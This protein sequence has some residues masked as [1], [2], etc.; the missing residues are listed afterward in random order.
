MTPDRPRA[1]RVLVSYASEDEPL[2]DKLG[3]HLALLVR[4]GLVEVWDQ[5]ALTIG[6]DVE[7]ETAAALERADLVLILASAAYHASDRWESEIEPALA[8]ER[9]GKCRVVPILARPADFNDP[10][11]ASHAVLPRSRI[12]VMSHPDPESAWAQV[13]EEIRAMLSAGRGVGT[14]GQPRVVRGAVK[15]LLIAPDEGSSLDGVK[16]ALCDRS[17]AGEVELLA[18]LTG[19]AASRDLLRGGLRNESPHVV[20]FLGSSTSVGDFAQDL[21]DAGFP[22]ELRLVVLEAC[23]L[24]S[25][26]AFRLAAELLS[27]AGA[28]AV[29]AHLRPPSADAA[30]RFY[31]ALTGGG[32]SSGDVA[33]SVNDARLAML[34]SPEESAKVSE[35]AKAASPALFMGGADGKI[36]DFT[37]RKVVPAP[38]PAQAAPSGP[39]RTGT[40][41]GV[42]APA[43][44]RIV[45]APFSLLLGDTFREL[46]KE[47]SAFRERLRKDLVKADA[48][49][50]P[51]LPMSA[52]TQRHAMHRGEQK[53][54]K[55]FQSVFQKPTDFPLLERLA[56]VIGPGVHTTLLRGPWFE[57][58]VARQ[59]PERTLYVVQP[60]AD[61]ITISRREAGGE[62]EWEELEDPPDGFEPDED[63]LFLRL[64]GGYTPQIVLT[65]PLLT[66]DDYVLRTNALQGAL[67]ADLAN[68]IL[69]VLEHRPA[70]ILGVSL[71]TNHHRMLLHRLYPRG[72][73]RES[74]AVIDPENT[75]R[76]L[77][78]K[79]AGLPGKAEGVHVIASTGDDLAAALPD[80]GAP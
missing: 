27:M 77:W 21:A 60:L 6:D 2:C 14:R 55:E 30:R 9:A 37:R 78:E 8:R 12:P 25:A 5:R 69:A 24:S 57:R 40:D 54:H 59:Q 75:E 62:E 65:H 67:P 11:F 46:R 32:Q 76:E 51:D 70:L 20:H 71:Y 33:R 79:G 58:S 36:F 23:D 31:E 10:L 63:I 13:A 17:A 47:L 26:Y 39:G 41:P 19:A 18:P 45:R 7:E 68:A 50:S 74:L 72:V 4:R 15:V 3:Q 43:L 16:N 73:P 49:A 1:V 29:V 80:G 52:L 38:L 34:M 61:G 28:D 56:R 22:S 53:L 44:R 48:P 35:S 42:A 66:E 64:Y